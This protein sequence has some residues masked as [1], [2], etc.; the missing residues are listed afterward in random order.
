MQSTTVLLFGGATIA[1]K[2]TITFKGKNEFGD[3]CRCDVDKSWQRLFGGD[4]GLS[5]DDGR[6]IMAAL[7]GAV[8]SHEAERSPLSCLPGLPRLSADQDYTARRIRTVSG[9]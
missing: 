8:V 4:I 2:W 9:Q 6:K 5:V 1:V 7:Q 3:V